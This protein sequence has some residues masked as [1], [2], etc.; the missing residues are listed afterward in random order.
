MEK[1]QRREQERGLGNRK[2]KGRRKRRKG[3]EEKGKKKRQKKENRPLKYF[4]WPFS[5]SCLFRAG[6]DISMSNSHQGELVNKYLWVGADICKHSWGIE[7]QVL[8]GY[9]L[10]KITP[11]LRIKKKN[12]KNKNRNNKVSVSAGNGAVCYQWPCFS[13]GRLN[14]RGDLK[15]E[16][17][18]QSASFDFLYLKNKCLL[19]NSFRKPVMK[20]SLD[21]SVGPIIWG[22][23]SVLVELRRESQMA[24]E[25]V[26]G[27]LIACPPDQQLG[28]L[29]ESEGVHLPERFLA[30]GWWAF[31]RTEVAA[32]DFVVLGKE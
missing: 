32:G 1:R 4:L 8:Q 16:W 24:G 22:H 7:S 26:S 23:W 20:L 10:V 30:L 28:G 11:Q 19:R 3:E 25:E 29:E 17:K 27:K 18:C 5:Q 21:C 14:L 9:R 15:S 31:P 6:R 12:N 2:Y 13:T